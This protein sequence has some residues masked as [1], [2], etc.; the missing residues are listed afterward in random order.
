VL[1]TLDGT[2][3]AT[4]ESLSRAH[5]EEV[6]PPHYAKLESWLATNNNTSD[7]WRLLLPR[8]HAAHRP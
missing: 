4:T 2:V 3:G 6:V 5:A 8:G 1:S 7:W